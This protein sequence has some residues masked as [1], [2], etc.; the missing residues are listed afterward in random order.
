[1]YRVNV[2]LIFA[3]VYFGLHSITGYF[4][5]KDNFCPGD[6]ER[7]YVYTIKDGDGKIWYI[8]NGKAISED[9]YKKAH[10]NLFEFVEKEDKNGKE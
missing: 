9:D 6:S 5:C 10:A 8:E 7:D 3:A 4:H 2:L 1:M